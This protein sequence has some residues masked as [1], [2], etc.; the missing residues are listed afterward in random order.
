MNGLKGTR[1]QSGRAGR[2]SRIKCIVTLI[3]EMEEEDIKMFVL[4]KMR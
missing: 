2:E 1:L 3:L 4:A